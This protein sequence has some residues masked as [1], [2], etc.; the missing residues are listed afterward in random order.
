MVALQYPHRHATRLYTARLIRP[1]DR[2]TLSEDKS[3][4]SRTHNESIRDRCWREGAMLVAPPGCDARSSTR[5]KYSTADALSPA[6]RPLL[7]CYLTSTG[8][9]VASNQL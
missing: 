6:R 7:F 2:F 5:P 3:Q 1:A 9:E 8:V 4:S